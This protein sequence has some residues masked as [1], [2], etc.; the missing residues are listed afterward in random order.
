MENRIVE[1]IISYLNEEKYCQAILIDGEWGSGKTFF[2]KEILMPKISKNISDKKVH[3]V[4]LYGVSSLEEITEKIYCSYVEEMI[5][6]NLGADKG[7]LVDDYLLNCSL[8]EKAIKEIVYKKATERKQVDDSIAVG[9][10]LSIKK[11]SNWKK[12]E[13]DEIRKTIK[14]IV[15][16]LETQKYEPGFFQ[17]IILTFFEL[18]DYEIMRNS[19]ETYSRIISAMG[20]KLKKDD[21]KFKKSYLEI[22]SNDTALIERYNALIEPLLKIFQEKE[23]EAVKDFSFVHE[24]WN[25][26]FPENCKKNSKDFL[27]NGKFF[28]YFEL[29]KF[30]NKLKEVPVKE[31]YNLIDGIKEI[32]E[33]ADIDKYMQSDI[34]YINE[35]LGQINVEEIA[36]EKI[37]KKLALK[38]LKQELQCC[39]SLVKEHYA[40]FNI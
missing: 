34:K 11:L 12:L 23:N 39:I 38:E 22:N 1:Q 36:G 35:I 15:E 7:K 3:Y 19:E 37:T 4:S 9:K 20:E 13:D 33:I 16:E 30:I 40:R 8:D 26:I 14:A 31:I 25:D 28:Y 5:D 17:K 10:A 27:K 21:G 6:K 18:Q 24:D 2:V 32:Y 29:E